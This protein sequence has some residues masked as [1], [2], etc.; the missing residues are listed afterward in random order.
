MCGRYYVK[1][2]EGEMQSIVSEI[3][4]KTQLSSGEI[5]P[6]NIVP[7][8]GVNGRPQAMKWGFPRYDGKGQVI[9]ARSETA[10]EKPMFRRLLQEGRCLIPASNYFEW[11][12]VGSKKKKYA[13]RPEGAGLMYMAGLSRP[14]PVTGMPLFVILT[15]EAAGGISFI[16]NRMPVILP[17]ASLNGWLGGNDARLILDKAEQNILYN[18]L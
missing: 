8:I 15:R 4:N 2:D 14:D 10:G 3:Q 5:Y 11:E 17:R 1:I 12:T 6:T 13:L 18:S 16:H 9:N 7:A